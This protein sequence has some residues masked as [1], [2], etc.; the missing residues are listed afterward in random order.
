MCVYV[1]AFIF[2]SPKQNTKKETVHQAWTL[3]FWFLIFGVWGHPKTQIPPDL[4][5]QKIICFCVLV[6]WGRFIKQSPLTPTHKQRR[7]LISR[8]L[9]ASDERIK[10]YQVCGDQVMIRSCRGQMR[11][12]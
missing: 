2:L 3:I 11:M 5:P 9:E 12:R 4:D 7:L 1:V 10:L 6:F 8:P